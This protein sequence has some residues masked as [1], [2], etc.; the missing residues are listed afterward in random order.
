[1]IFSVSNR[2]KKSLLVFTDLDGTLLDHETYRFDDARPALQILKEKKFPLI[3]CSSKT[4]AEIE[5]CRSKLRLVHP[6]I[7]ENGAA[8]FIPRNYFPFSFSHDRKDSHY[9][10]IELG[11]S[12]SELRAALEKIKRLFPRKIRGF[13]DLTAEETARV[14]G[15]SLAQASLAKKRDYDEPFILKDKKLEPEIE[16]AARS[17]RLKVT[18]GSRFYH[19][20]GANDKGKAVSLLVDICRQTG[21]QFITI[22]LGDSLNDLPMLEAVDCPVLV[23]KPDGSYDPAVKLRNLSYAPAPGPE[24]FRISVLRL[25]DQFA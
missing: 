8:V 14:C 6:F 22:G 4:R 15:F 7:A 5:A 9:F 13:G 25:I 21:N 3:I 23:Q 20:L 2:K 1:M 16:K 12:Y 24:G 11:T 19:L 10:I 17:L 18:R